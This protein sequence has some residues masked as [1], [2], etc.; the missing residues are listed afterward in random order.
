MNADERAC[1]VVPTWNEREN[2]VPLVKAV[3]SAGANIHVL[4]VDDNSP[5]GTGDVA[6]ELARGEPRVS[7]MHRYGQRGRGTA[8]R[9]GFVRCMEEGF[10]FILEMDAD[11]SHDPADI[12]RLV[13]AAR[14]ADVVLGSRLV[15]GG[16]QEGRSFGRRFIT[17]G[18]NLYLRI[19]L[20]MPRVRD[21]TSGFRCFRRAA[22]VAADVASIRSRG[23]S[24]VTELLF[25]CRGMRIVEV[26]VVFR[27]RTV[28]RSKFGMKAM[29]E[30]LLMPPKLWF[31]RF[32]RRR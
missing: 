3:M 15:A 5:D 17:S 10:E 25:R 30:S 19:A 23:P 24:I 8:G 12:P 4:I 6:D 1:V 9:D 32:T 7:V 16:R 11:L 14:D 2:I 27:D 26:P 29:I 20:A 28:G 31:W 18:A 21:C 13:A 22:L